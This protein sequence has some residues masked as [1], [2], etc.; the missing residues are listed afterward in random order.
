MKVFAKYNLIL[1]ILPKKDSISK[2]HYIQSLMCLTN[3]FYDQIDIQESKNK[4]LINYCNAHKHKIYFD[5]CLIKKAICFCE[6]LFKRK[7]YLN[8][9]VIK[10]IPVAAGLGGGSADASAIILWILN[11]YRLRLSPNDLLVIAREVGSDV[12]F[13]L[14]KYSCAQVSGIGN[15]VSKVNMSFA[16]DILLTNKKILTKNVYK[17]LNQNKAYRSKVSYPSLLTLAKANKIDPKAIYND[18]QP[19]VLKVCP[20]LQ[21]ILKTNHPAIV[22][23]SGSSI[24]KL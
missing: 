13:F 11:K 6:K 8:I 1:K 17:R 18:L 19:Y 15:I 22:C 14:S 23:G 21:T 4:L 16:H 9:K 2:K 24:I 7:F 20:S 3:Q 5:K 10:G 12:P